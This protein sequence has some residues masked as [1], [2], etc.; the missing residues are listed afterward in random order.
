MYC[1]KDIVLNQCRVAYLLI[2][3]YAIRA[4][5]MMSKMQNALRNPLNSDF[6][7]LSATASFGT[8]DMKKTCPE[9]HVLQK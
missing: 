8:T 5:F 2:P 3:M 6:Q 9:L 1:K 4:T 7:F